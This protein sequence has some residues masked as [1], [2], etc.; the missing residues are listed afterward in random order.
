MRYKGHAN[1]AEQWFAVHQVGLND[2]YYP[3]WCL[4]KQQCWSVCFPM[5]GWFARP[6]YGVVQS[7]SSFGGTQTDGSREFG[8]DGFQVL[9]VKGK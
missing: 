5:Y 7:Y 2:K 1:A 6:L 9:L 4:R 8:H 3:G